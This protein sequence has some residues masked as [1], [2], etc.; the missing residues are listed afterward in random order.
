MKTAT[1][2]KDKKLSDSDTK[3]MRETFVY[4]Y[5][6]NKGWDVAN[7]T[8]EQVLEIREHKEWKTPGILKS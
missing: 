3:E 5:C 8:F 1:L 6:I 7:L 2:I 4:N